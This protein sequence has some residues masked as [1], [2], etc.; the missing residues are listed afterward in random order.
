MMPQTIPGIV[1]MPRVS[2]PKQENASDAMAKGEVSF[3]L[4]DFVSNKSLEPL[5]ALGKF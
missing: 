5:A 4:M 3:G 1:K 2:A